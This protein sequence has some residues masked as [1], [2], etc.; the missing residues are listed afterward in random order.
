MATAELEP[1]LAGGAA[2]VVGAAVV[3]AAVVVVVPPPAVELLLQATAINAI[4]A[5][6][7]PN[8]AARAENLR[9][10]VFLPTE[11]D[12][13]RICPSPAHVPYGSRHRKVRS[14]E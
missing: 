8:A 2:V 6:D 7:T 4:A 11:V 3:A 5:T 10:M 9:G 13:S 14:C 1:E 12:Q